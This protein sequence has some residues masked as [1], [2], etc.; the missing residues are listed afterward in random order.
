MG[1]G[2]AGSKDKE[3]LKTEKAT[4]QAIK[5]PIKLKWERIPRGGTQT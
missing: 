5:A 4:S 3:T 1:G 2:G